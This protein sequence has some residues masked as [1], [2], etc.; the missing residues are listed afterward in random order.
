M[1]RLTV[2][3]PD[4][5]MNQVLNQVLL[6]ERSTES[7]LL[8]ALSQYL[9]NSSPLEPDI[10]QSQTWKLCGQFSVPD[11]YPTEND[12]DKDNTIEETN[13]AEHVDET[14]YKGF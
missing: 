8:E 1:A 2:E 3:V 6:V 14:L 9:E 13:Y 4:E 12:P 11:S 5:L 10:T 7:V